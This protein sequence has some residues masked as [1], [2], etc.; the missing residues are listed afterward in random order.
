MER[1]LRPFT[2][3]RLSSAFPLTDCC[4]QPIIDFP[5]DQAKAREGHMTSVLVPRRHQVRCWSR[6]GQSAVA[7]TTLPSCGQELCLPPKPPQE[8]QE[9]PFSALQVG[10]GQSWGDP[11][12]RRLT[13][14]QDTQVTHNVHTRV[15]QAMMASDVPHTGL[16]PSQ[17]ILSVQHSRTRW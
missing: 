17:Q 12:C 14:Q 4:L 13:D 1:S 10:V 3:L 6:T 15:I 9:E 5:P 7:G 16:Q 2:D 8:G 11:A